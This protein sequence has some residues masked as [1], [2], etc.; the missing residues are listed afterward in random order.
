EPQDS[1][2]M[3]KSCRARPAGGGHA[4]GAPAGRARQ[5]LAPTAPPESPIA[6][7][8]APAIGSRDV[9]LARWLMRAGLWGGEVR[10]LSRGGIGLWRRG[11]RAAGFRRYDEILPCP[12]CGG[13]ARLRRTRLGGPVRIWH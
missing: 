11:R 13:R 12:P 6:F 4:F 8:C 2:G 5:D 10:C 7:A 9:P 1:G 3:T